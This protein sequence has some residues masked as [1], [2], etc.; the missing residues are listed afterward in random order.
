MGKKSVKPKIA[1]T[2]K[3]A[4]KGRRKFLAVTAAAGGGA[5]LGAPHVRN[6]EAAK[7]TTW[8]VQTS[9]PGGIGLD[10]F[11]NWCNGIIEETG[12]EL[13]F[14]PFAIAQVSGEGFVIAFTQ[15]PNVRAYLDGPAACRHRCS[16]VPTRSACGPR[17]SGTRSSMG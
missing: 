11:K 4:H 5:I 3:S 16:S 14:K 9:W 15:D 2:A 1:G 7:T 10:L 8:N 12:G 6:A 13:A 17:V